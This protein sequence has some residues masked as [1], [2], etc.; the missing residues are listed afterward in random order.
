[1]NL[2]DE[3]RKR[4][5][6]MDGAMGTQI[7]ARNIPADAWQG[8]DGCNELLNLT[9]P[10]II[11]SIHEAYFEAGS[12]AVETNTF[13]ASPVTL[14]EY[15]LS[16]KAFEINRAAAKLAREAADKYSTHQQPRFV[17]GSIGPG[18]KLPTLGQ[19]P[20]DTLC[21]SFQKQIEGLL[22]GGA[23]GIL[24][25]TCQD[26][27]Q[28]KAGLVAYDKVVG[29]KHSVPLYVSVTVEQTG[30]LLIGSSISAVVATLLPF[31]VDILGLNCATG[32]DAMRIHLDYLA[33]NW[34]GFIACMPNAGLPQMKDGKVSYP[35]G[36][37]AF[38]AALGKLTRDVGL[39]VIGGCCGTTP[40]HI[41]KLR[42]AIDGI[43]V[44][45]R[46]TN[47]PEQVSSVFSPV[48]LTQEP[49]PLY[50]G[51]RANA[52]G[53]KKFRDA[54]L[55]DNYDSAFA[56][57]IEQEEVGAHVVDLSCAYAGRDEAKDIQILTARAGRECRIP[58]M[59]DTTQADVAEEALKLYGGRAIV[60]SINFESGEERSSRVAEMARRYGAALVCLTIDETGMAM[61][62][63]RKVSI[64]K[65]LVDF[66]EKHGLRRGDLFID[67]LT[68]TIGSGDDNLRNCAVETIEAIRR[69][70]SEIPGVRTL[71]GLSNISFGLK[72]AGRKV[73]N[74]VFLDKCLKA[75]LDSCI[76]NVA[77]I[78]PLNQIPYGAVKVAEAL[79]NNDR[80][81]GDPL[82]NFINFFET[83][84][85]ESEAV[86]AAK[87]P[88]ETLADAVIKG[89]VPVLAEVIP[90]LLKS[91]KAEDI[92][93]KLLIPA[94]QEVGRLFNEGILQLPF[95]LKSAEVMKKAVDM[96]KPYM[97]KDESASGRGTMVIATVA[98]DVHD[99]GKNL[100]DIILSNNGFKVVNLGTK[101]PV[102]QM[103]AAVREHK[104]DVLGM[105]G[106]LVKSAA[107]MAENMKAL[108]AS[109]IRI[110]IFLGGAAL[111]PGFVANDCQPKYSKPVV[112]C[113]DAFDGLT[114]MRERSEKGGLEKTAPR[115]KEPVADESV[116]APVEIDL[117]APPPAVPFL[118]P[119]VIQNLSIE[120]L[121]PYLN[122]VALVRGRWGYRR[123]KLSAEEYEK[124]LANEVRPKL[125]AM[126]N[127]CVTSGLFKPHVAYG[128]FHCH[129]EGETLW[130][131]P[132]E[133]A[134]PIPLRFP[135]QARSPFVSIPDFFR[136]D[137]DV[138]GFM[139]VTLHKG[140]ASKNIELLKKDKYQEYFL[141][142][143][144]AVE[145]TDALAEY[146]HAYMR[147][148]LGFAD[149]PLN[150]QD[151][152][153]QKY[154]GS[155]YGFGYPACPDLSMN[156]I[157][158]DLVHAD[159]ID[160]TVTESFMLDP[161]IST[162]ALVA[163]HPKAKYFNV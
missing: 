110:P 81:V 50:I 15:D 52:T 86:K 116:A 104:A 101:V 115:L 24:F 66:C 117:S 154:R 28:I 99:I 80:S 76:I 161:E 90:V 129:G 32:P 95:V 152:V 61:N 8:K 135:R 128:Y 83:V 112:Y 97:Q 69:I 41:Q 155:R 107:I 38:G 160:V 59:I 137:L 58:I 49:P 132:S 17:F 10:D 94:M 145:L 158:C 123:G 14:G 60:N 92:L 147:R 79:L 42:L 126:K 149:P 47:R 72:P 22:D 121:Y 151:Y 75:G 113:K 40:E 144:F 63:E 159:K 138:V 36:P 156:K 64:A 134:E 65:R 29:Q 4:V 108:E 109:D 78:A 70:K 37:F 102:E 91:Y 85:E 3:I 163:H 48:D 148:E 30:T 150:T 68:F 87:S 18:T 139:V 20:F 88:E 142:H 89:R 84:V 140:L 43:P 1:M 39:D 106:L 111:T 27:L 26:I 114:R 34:P 55:A 31:P 127:D 136:R 45:R 122:E 46:Q 133:S 98:G 131:H 67:A 93:N 62:A 74:A 130:V 19:I 56:I 125:D 119:R 124:I 143:G 162:S 21:G 53:S 77:T 146:W 33:Q 82:E 6:L 12:D 25:E 44:V 71:L 7:Q 57:L 73:L 54:L 120:K 11:R 141:L 9:A 35:L 103:M 153:V 2:L 5:F 16:D 100:V 105:S 96:I 23:Y 13:G 157:V 118:G 51:E